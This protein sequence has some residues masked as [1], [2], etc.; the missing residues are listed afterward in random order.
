MSRVI[1]IKSMTLVTTAVIPVATRMRGD[2]V[3]HD[4]SV[5]QGGK[6]NAHGIDLA[7]SRLF[8]G[9]FAVR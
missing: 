8:V 4:G 9:E 6:A 5:I 7:G 3:S 1:A 2:G